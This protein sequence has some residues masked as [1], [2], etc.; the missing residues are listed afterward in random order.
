[1]FHC[2]KSLCSSLVCFLSLLFSTCL[3][4]IIS[5]IARVLGLPFVIDV[6]QATSRSGLTLPPNNFKSCWTHVLP[7]RGRS[8]GDARFIH[9]GVN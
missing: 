5:A 6:C 7:C 3:L 1:M 9:D 2:R 4:G 8:A